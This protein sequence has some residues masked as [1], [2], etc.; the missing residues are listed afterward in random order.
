MAAFGFTVLFAFLDKEQ[1]PRLENFRE[2]TA[3]GDSAYFSRPAAPVEIVY[4]GKTYLTEAETFEEKDS[5]MISAGETST[6]AW[7]VY[8][9]QKAE[10]GRFFLKIATGEYLPI[11]ARPE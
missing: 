4:G 7:R 11:S 9:S 3:V 1:R 10:P 6:G 8:R 2:Q 5:R